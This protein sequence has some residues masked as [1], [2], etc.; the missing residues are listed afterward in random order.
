MEVQDKVIGHKIWTIKRWASVEDFNAGRV[1]SEEEELQL[2]GISQDSKFEGNLL[3]NEGIN[4]L[5]TLVCSG[6]GTKFDSANARLAVG[7]SSAAESAAHT[8]LQ[9][10]TNKLYKAMDVGF[11]TFGTLQKAVWR[12]TYATSEANFAWQEFTVANGGSDA[13]INLNRKV[14]NQGTKISGQVWQLTLEITLS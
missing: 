11:P 14:S 1:Y 12:S 10:S 5:W 6:G 2:M 9:A 4:E 7:D 13:A 8:G 3:L